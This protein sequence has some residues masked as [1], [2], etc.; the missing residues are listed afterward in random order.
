MN[1]IQPLNL[2]LKELEV[3]EEESEDALSKVYAHIFEKAFNNLRLRNNT[4]NGIA[5]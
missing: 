1:K 2:T 4:K 5:H 3:P